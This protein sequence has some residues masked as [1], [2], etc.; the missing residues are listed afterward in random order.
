[1]SIA[2]EIW[3]SFRR[4]P[5]AVQAWVALW[6]APINIAALAFL[7]QRNGVLIAVLA[8]GGMAPNMF[9]MMRE[10][11][12]SALM[13]L[14]HLVIWT[15]LVVVA[16]ITLFSGVGSGYAIFLVL[17]LITDVVSLVFD[18]KDFAAWRAG[19]RAIA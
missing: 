16:L 10:R 3:S 11:G 14:P 17:L 7:G 8:I 12:L 19:D 5:L 6:L 2:N 18:V 4:L 15:P 1:M 9:I 13:A